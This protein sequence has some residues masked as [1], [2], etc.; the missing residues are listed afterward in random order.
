MTHLPILSHAMHLL[1]LQTR[2]ATPLY[3]AAEVGLVESMKLL[4][5]A[6]AD[7]DIA[8][9]RCRSLCLCQLLLVFVPSFSC[10]SNWYL[11]S[12]STM[13]IVQTD[14]TTPLYMAAVKG[15]LEPMKLLISA[16]AD[17]NKSTVRACH[18]SSH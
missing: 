11:S 15:R 12:V 7:L 8:M 4:I 13:S 16:G 18:A 5:S 9:V 6:G 14:G 3:V 10:F 1:R 2:G 17:L